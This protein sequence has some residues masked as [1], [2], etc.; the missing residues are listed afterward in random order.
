MAMDYFTRW[1]EAAPLHKV[2]EYVVIN[3]LQENI[4][5]RFGVPIS[6]VVYNAS[7]F[8]YIKIIEFSCEKG[9]KLHYLTN[10]Y[11]RGNGLSVSTNKNLIQIL[12]ETVIENQRN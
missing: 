11:P 9:I 5:T 8:S 10:Y 1:V 3:F 6:L 7:Y 2:S 4:M 12:K